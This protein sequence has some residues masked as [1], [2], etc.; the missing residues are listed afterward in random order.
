MNAITSS[1]ET[2]VLTAS[3]LNE[4]SVRLDQQATRSSP[5]YTLQWRQAQLLVKPSQSV[6]QPELSVLKNKEGLVR[7]LNRSPVRLVRIDPA[8]GQTRLQRW[9]DACEQAGKQVFLSIPSNTELPRKLRPLT[10]YIKR[11][12]DWGVA[13]L[14]LVILSPVLLA[15]ALLIRI[16]S[17]GSIFF[18]QWR[19]GKRGRLFRIIK[20][21]T[22]VVNAEQFHHQVMGDLP[23]LHKLEDDPRVTPLGRWMRKYSLDELPQLIN[24]LRGEMSLVGPRPWA[25]YDAVRLSPD[26]Q[27]R[28]NARPGITGLWHV[29]PRANLLDIE[30]V[31]RWDLDYLSNWTLRQD[32]KLLVATIPKVL[33]G[34]GAY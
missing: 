32:L 13:A 11:I 3:P 2:R 19:I 25:L 18:Q 30:A 4:F 10:W 15:L 12:L 1:R 29:Q 16:D 8:L 20:F 22:M 28:L 17:P 5:P 26:G 27:R 23:G 14:L 34:C 21:R 9:A 7:C 31:N 33:S 24:V 6:K